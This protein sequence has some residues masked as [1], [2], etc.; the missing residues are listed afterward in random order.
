MMM[1]LPMLI[2]AALLIVGCEGPALQYTKEGGTEGE[3]GHDDM[4]CEGQN[5]RQKEPMIFTIRPEWSIGYSHTSRKP[6]YEETDW[7]AV[8]KCLLEKGWRHP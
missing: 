8:D 7:K 1:W 5:Y 3:F 4:I 6:M 2:V